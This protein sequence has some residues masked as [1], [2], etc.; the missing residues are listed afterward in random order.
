V[1]DEEQE[2]LAKCVALMEIDSIDPCLNM[3][4]HRKAEHGPG[5]APF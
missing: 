1:R 2:M 4:A 3:E 5:K